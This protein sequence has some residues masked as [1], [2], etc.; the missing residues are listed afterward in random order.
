MAELERVA[1]SPDEPA[2]FQH[3]GKM[4]LRY[5]RIRSRH[6]AELNASSAVR[7]RGFSSRFKRPRGGP[8]KLRQQYRG[9]MYR[10]LVMFPRSADPLMV[11]ELVER[12]AAAYKQ[13]S[14]FRSVTTSVDAPMGPSAKD[15]EIGRIMEADFDT[16]DDALAVLDA[17]SFQS[18]KA[19]TESLA[20]S[21]LLYE[22]REL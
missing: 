1:A 22:N 10:H 16:L 20:S 9:R 12:A 4:P 21:L 3:P 18:I 19:A 15:G 13:C 14:G 5:V 11:D 2:K 6:L 17:E 8:A 7:R